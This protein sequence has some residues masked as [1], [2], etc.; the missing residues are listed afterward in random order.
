MM[1][2]PPQQTTNTGQRRI[3]TEGVEAPICGRLTVSYTQVWSATEKP[4][5]QSTQP[6]VKESANASV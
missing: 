4:A 3:R 5:R 2:S 1:L 6:D